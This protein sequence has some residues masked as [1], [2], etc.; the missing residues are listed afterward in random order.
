[1]DDT[2]PTL[3]KTPEWNP[4]NLPQADP[5][6]SQ[7][8]DQTTAPTEMN[9]PNME[10]A[11][12]MPANPQ[13]NIIDN[14]PVPESP[15]TDVSQFATE[16]SITEPMVTTTTQM[17][18]EPIKKRGSKV[19]LF[20]FIVLVIILSV[21]L[22][23][24]SGV[25]VAYGKI[26]LS[27]KNIQKTIQ[28][29]VF[30]LPFMPKTPEWVLMSSIKAHESVSSAYLNASVAIDSDAMKNIPDFLGISSYDMSVTGPIDLTD[31]KNPTAD[32]NIKIMNQFD[33]DIKSLDKSFYFKVNTFPLALTAMLGMGVNAPDF[34]TLLNTWVKYDTSSETQARKSLDSQNEN[35]NTYFDSKYSKTIEKLL[36]DKILPLAKMSNEQIEGSNTHKIVFDIPGNIL[37]DISRELESE[38]EKPEAIYAYVPPKP[39][40]MIKKLSV[41]FWIDTKSYYMKKGEVQLTYKSP[42]DSTASSTI[43]DDFYKD[44]DTGSEIELLATVE[45]SRFGEKFTI[46]TPENAITAEEFIARITNLLGGSSGINPLM[47]A[48]FSEAQARVQS[49]TL[50]ASIYHADNN[51]YPSNLQELSQS[52]FSNSAFLTEL[53]GSKIK[54]VSNV[55]GDTMIVY[56]T[57]TDPSN[58][59]NPYYVISVTDETSEQRQNMTAGELNS[60]LDGLGAQ[61]DS[62]LTTYRDTIIPPSDAPSI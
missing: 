29:I 32:L 45:M 37:D 5:D 40:E 43:L 14:Y 49:V 6:I 21:C 58:T 12:D 9:L 4:N 3:D 46:D 59:T 1:M 20:A 31:E 52:Q 61:P 19:R 34:S 50:F 13:G 10:L 44:S 11:Q 24:G 42:V 16:P 2:K 30:K 18:E 39:S 56:S 26:P 33:M 51:R 22:L 25:M 8:T 53:E 17:T 41:T 27:D 55:V 47:S 23:L 62:E 57:I 15:M 54:L 48:E 60:L 35:K 7:S 38:S 28:N 36:T